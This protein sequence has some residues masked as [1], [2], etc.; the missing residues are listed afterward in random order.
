MTD[1]TEPRW[2]VGEITITRVD[3]IELPSQTG[4]WLLPGATKELVGKAEWLHPDFA[5]SERTLRLA[6]H[7]FAVR[8]GDQRILVDTAIGNGKDRANPAWHNLGTDY[9]ERLTEVGFRPEDVDLVIITHLHTDHVGWNTRLHNGLWVPT[10]PNAR[11]LVSRIEW[12]YW[13]SVDKDAAREQMFRDSVFPVHDSGLFELVDVPTGGTEVA[14]GVRLLPTPGHTPGQVAVWIENSGQRA[15]ITGDSV[16]HPVQLAHP[17]VTSCV[18]IDPAQAQRTRLEL[19]ESIAD[20]ETLLLGTHF[21]APTGGVV[22]QEGKG[23]RLAP[24]PH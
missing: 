23:Y 17:H 3:E 6:S 2:Q 9:L 14:P 19:F 22:R 11:Y 10:F 7:S 16:H 8:V 5:D 20:T 21:P 4:P 24:A 13:S 12:D 15:V 1:T 18:D